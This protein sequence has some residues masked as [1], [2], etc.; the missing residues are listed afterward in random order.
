MA[1]NQP[2]FHVL[3]PTMAEPMEVDDSFESSPAQRP[4]ENT[5]PRRPAN[6]SPRE[7]PLLMYVT[8]QSPETK[9]LRRRS[10][11]HVP[12][13][14]DGSQSVVGDSNWSAE[15]SVVDETESLYS[16]L[17]QLS[18]M[19][20][21]S[22]NTFLRP[23]SVRSAPPGDS[24]SRRSPK[25]E[26]EGRMSGLPRRE[27]VEEDMPG[28]G[29]TGT[30][31]WIGRMLWLSLIGLVLIAILISRIGPSAEP[32]ALNPSMQKLRQFLSKEIHDQEEALNA[33]VRQLEDFIQ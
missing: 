21:S 6:T 20:A 31:R 18:T 17:S 19:T 7:N 13:S 27:A 23:R 32:P 26:A 24:P 15:E 2:S 28:L 5:S 8:R 1:I 29:S 33:L 25:S 14:P 10:P 4:L 11:K 16:A 22:S 9:F 30:A 3:R 12:D